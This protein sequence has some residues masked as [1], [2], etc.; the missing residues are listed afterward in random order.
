MSDIDDTL[1]NIVL[2]NKTKRKILEK[3]RN[4]IFVKKYLIIIYL[5]TSTFKYPHESYINYDQLRYLLYNLTLHNLLYEILT[6][7]LSLF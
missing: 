6:V 2:S 4:K 3:K 5:N 7:F 1:K